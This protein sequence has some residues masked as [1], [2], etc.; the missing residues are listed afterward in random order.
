[1][2]ELMAMGSQLQGDNI[3][4][5]I[6]WQPNDAFGQV[7]GAERGGHV[8]GVGFGPNPFGNCVSS[9][10]DITPPP[11]SNTTDQRVKE[12]F[13]QVEA[14]K[15]KC[16]RYDAIEIEVW[17]MRRMLTQMYP[18]F[19]TISTVRSLNYKVCCVSY[20]LDH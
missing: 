2:R 8:R 10:D 13:A 3:E 5:G 20:L 12:L 15:E 6:L 19:P 7:I 9:M 16:T 11:T 4:V 14:M 1:M 18:S 17:L